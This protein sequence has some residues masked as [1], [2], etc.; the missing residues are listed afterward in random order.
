MLRK[1]IDAWNN[2]PALGSVGDFVRLINCRFQAIIK[3]NDK[4]KINSGIFSLIIKA[5]AVID[6]AVE[7]NHICL[8]TDFIGATTGNIGIPAAA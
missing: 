5:A 1:T 6:I 4:I 3:I 8:I 7:W 2:L